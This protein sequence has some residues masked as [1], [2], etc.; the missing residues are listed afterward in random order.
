MLNTQGDNQHLSGNVQKS[1]PTLPHL[2]DPERVT[3]SPQTLESLNPEFE[4]DVSWA[5]WDK[6]VQNG[7]TQFCHSKYKVEYPGRWRRV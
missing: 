5:L 1:S 2:R 6:F 7:E 4:L 3:R